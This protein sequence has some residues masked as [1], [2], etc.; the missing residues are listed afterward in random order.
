MK[1]RLVT[2]NGTKL[3]EEVYE[4]ILPTADGEISVFT[5]H[6]PVVTVAVPG[7]ITVR[8]RQ[9]DSDDQTE[10]YAVT[11]GVIEI[12]GK[13]INI[14]VDEADHSSDIVETEVKQALER[15]LKLQE[16]ATNQVELEKAHQ[17]VD[18]HMVRLKVADMH[19]RHRRQ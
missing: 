13:T 7:V 9:T 1:L 18:R 16:A 15:A 10:V 11:G 6:E 5:D 12:D 19:R 3:D 14:L 8:R 2:L 4:A 17:L